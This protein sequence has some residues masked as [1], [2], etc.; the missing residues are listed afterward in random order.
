MHSLEDGR[1]GDLALYTDDKDER[2]GNQQPQGIQGTCAQS[3]LFQCQLRPQAALRA[4]GSIS[5]PGGGR[6]PHF[7]IVLMLEFVLH[8]IQR[9]DRMV[10]IRLCSGLFILF[11]YIR[12]LP[13]PHFLNQAPGPV[14]P[15]PTQLSACCTHT[16]SREFQDHCMFTS[17]LL[18]RPEASIPQAVG[19][20]S[21]E[22]G[23]PDVALL[24]HTVPTRPTPP[25]SQSAACW[26]LLLALP[27]WASTHLSLLSPLQPSCPPWKYMPVSCSRPGEVKAESFLSWVV[28]VTRLLDHAQFSSGPPPDPRSCV[29]WALGCLPAVCLCLWFPRSQEESLGNSPNS[30][31]V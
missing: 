18:P 7:Q 16:L 11:I 9:G 22:P 14:Y 28:V 25:P 1:P 19:K 6:P 3:Q 27:A 20:S 21:P 29:S 24:E 17:K 30:L 4:Y 15:E 8:V 10:L 31:L 5:S 2:S 12:Y 26:C 23:T 13:K